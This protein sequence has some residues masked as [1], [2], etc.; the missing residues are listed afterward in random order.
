MYYMNVYKYIVRTTRRHPLWEYSPQLYAVNISKIFDSHLVL[1]RRRPL[2][3]IC[4]HT[5]ITYTI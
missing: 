1:A 2:K 3:Y 4:V 5:R